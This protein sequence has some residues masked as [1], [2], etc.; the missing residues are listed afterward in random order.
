M[1]KLCDICGRLLDNPY[2]PNSVNCGGTCRSCMAA[3]GD[4]DCIRELQGEYDHTQLPGMI[5]L[6]M[7]QMCIL[8]VQKIL[9]QPRCQRS[10]M[11]VRI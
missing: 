8:I 2:D 5:T 3:A 7:V 9:K 1:Y 4:T 6:Q 11:L 10:L